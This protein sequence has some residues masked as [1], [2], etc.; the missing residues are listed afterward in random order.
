VSAANCQYMGLRANRLREPNDGADDES[1][2][3]KFEHT[4]SSVCTS[5]LPVPWM[6][7]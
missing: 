2:Q 6:L 5:T 3:A 4:H 1:E 7:P